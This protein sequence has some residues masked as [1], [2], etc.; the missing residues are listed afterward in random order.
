MNI[1]QVPAFLCFR[2]GWSAWA[3]VARGDE[4]ERRGLP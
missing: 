4:A 1:G 3:G 2:I